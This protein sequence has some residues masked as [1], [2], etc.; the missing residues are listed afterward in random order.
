MQFL[1]LDDT[2]RMMV[3]G[4]YQIMSTLLNLGLRGYDE[5]PHFWTF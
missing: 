5:K 1:R 4:Y 2:F 3:T